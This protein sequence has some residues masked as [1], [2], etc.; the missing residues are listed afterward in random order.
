MIIHSSHFQSEIGSIERRRSLLQLL[1][2]ICSKTRIG[3]SFRLNLNYR[4]SQCMLQI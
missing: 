1:V 2:R 3:K 4:L